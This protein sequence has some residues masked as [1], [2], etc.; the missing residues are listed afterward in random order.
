M[1]LSAFLL[2]PYILLPL[3]IWSLFWKGLALWKAGTRKEKIW[4]IILLL[5]NTIG[6]LEIIYL[7]TRRRTKKKN[8]N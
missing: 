7:L 1:E 3:I 8:K 2:Q 4:F 6:I 5:V